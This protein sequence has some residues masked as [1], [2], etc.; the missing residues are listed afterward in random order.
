MFT[1]VHPG[2]HRYVG[3]REPGDP[4]HPIHPELESIPKLLS[5]RGYKSS[6][7]VSH[8]R[9]LPE[10]GFGRGFDRFKLH[11]MAH[12]RWNT[13]ETDT[14]ATVDQLI[15]WLDVDVGN[16][17]VFYFAHLFDAHYPYYPPR[18]LYDGDSVDYDVVQRFTD[19]R[20]DNSDY[21]KLVR[22]LDDPMDPQVLD[23][24]KRYY[25]QSVDYIGS[26]LVRLFDRLETHGLYDDALII[27]TGDHGEEFGERGVYSHTSLY[28]ENIR[29]A[30]LVKPPEGSDW[31]V[32]TETD[33]LD[34]LPTIARA[35][36]E[37]PPP[38]CP[39]IPWQEDIPDRTRIT[40]RIDPDWY[41][42]SVEKE[43]IKGIFTYSD[44]FPDR[45][46]EE[47][48]DRGP[49]YEEFYRLE[50]VREGDTGDHAESIDEDR[51]RHL[52]D[53]AA[54][55]VTKKPIVDDSGLAA[56]TDQETREHLRQLGYF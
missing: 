16:P 25:G 49:E 19:L 40:E 1:G 29:P 44:N 47:T 27:I 55:F 7:I 51:K 53:K 30:V 14:R 37:S 38:Y 52:R 12:D 33:E 54:S 23:E 6:A 11:K 26:Q 48:I 3:A 50:A 28:D 42:V 13:R 10:F 20:P 34:I 43:G 5:R 46:T 4:S 21:L 17:N 56:E 35:V 8:T 24:I 2:D 36:G 18:S 9:I 45:P 31:S 32:P 41:N 15:E 22:S 39:G